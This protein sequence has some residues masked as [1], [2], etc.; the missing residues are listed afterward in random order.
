MPTRDSTEDIIREG[1]G[2]QPSCC[3][4]LVTRSGAAEREQIPTSLGTTCSTSITLQSDRRHRRRHISFRPLSS[5]STT[6]L[7]SLRYDDMI[8]YWTEYIS[9]ASRTSRKP[10]EIEAWFQRTT[11]KKRPVWYRMVT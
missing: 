11:R 2:S 9:S 3:S 1:Y 6:L 5:L 10:S 8:Q 7:V 4:L